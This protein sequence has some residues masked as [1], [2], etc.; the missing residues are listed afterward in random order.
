MKK[1]LIDIDPLT[2]TETWHYYDAL[3]DETY[4][5][6]VQDVQPYLERNKRLANDADYR[7]NG[8]KESWW[9]AASIPNAIITKWLREFG[10]DVYNRDHWPRVKRLLNDPDYRYLRTGTGRL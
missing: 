6:E 1:D 2:R 8:I 4:I 7:A 9:H 3:T 10:V 5:E